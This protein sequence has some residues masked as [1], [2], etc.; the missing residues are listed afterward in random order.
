MTGG[1]P[2]VKTYERIFEIINSEEL[3]NIFVDFLLIF[4]IS[5]NNVENDIIDLDGRI[6]K[7][8]SRNICRK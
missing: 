3:E 4:N 2:C 1:I 8:S 6:T 7:G 5:N